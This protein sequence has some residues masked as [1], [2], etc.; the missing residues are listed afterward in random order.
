[1][2]ETDQGISAFPL[3]WPYGWKRTRFPGKGKFGVTFARARD[4]LVKEVRLLGGE[5]LILSSNIP[6]R[7]DGLPSGD[8]DRQPADAGVALY[9][10]YHDKQ[11]CFASDSY[12][13]VEDNMRALA[14]TIGAIRGIERWGASDMMERAF[15][16]FLQLASPMAFDWRDV[17]GITTDADWGDA[18]A[19]YKTARSAA[20]PDKGGSPEAFSRVEEAFKAAKQYYGV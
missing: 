1:M 10:T 11:M 16:G 18:E 13:K 9:F 15:T 4:L 17:L 6:L 3:T 14:L 8:V 2:T 20:H 12:L 7:K 5:K 19:A